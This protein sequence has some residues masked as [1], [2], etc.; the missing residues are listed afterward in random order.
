MDR[1]PVALT[2]L[3]GRHVGG[4]GLVEWAFV[5]VEAGCTEWTLPACGMWGFPRHPSLFR[6]EVAAITAAGVVIYGFS[7]SHLSPNLLQGDHGLGP[8]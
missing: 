2:P 6:Y 1:Q 8:L 4:L 7:V 5:F 3:T